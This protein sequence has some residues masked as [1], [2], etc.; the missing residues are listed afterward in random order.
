[1]LYSITSYM[2]SERFFP[3][4]GALADFSKIFLGEV[5]SEISV[6]PTRN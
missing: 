3:G 5:K 6:S 4:G 1:M 2:T